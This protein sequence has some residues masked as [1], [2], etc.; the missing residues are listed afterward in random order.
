MQEVERRGQIVNVDCVLAADFEFGHAGVVGLRVKVIHLGAGVGLWLMIV[1]RG[2]AIA[3]L[4][5]LL[6]RLAQGAVRG[7][8]GD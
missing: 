5:L 3:V 8:E 1:G 7:S 2:V 4:L 6:L